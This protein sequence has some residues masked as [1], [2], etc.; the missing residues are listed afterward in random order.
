VINKERKRKR[1]R[2]RERERT[3]ERAS[4]FTVNQVMTSYGEL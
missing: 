4:I 3:R 1:E 2:E